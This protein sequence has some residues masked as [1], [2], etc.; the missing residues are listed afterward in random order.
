MENGKGVN[1]VGCLLVACCL[2]LG[3]IIFFVLKNIAK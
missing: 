1:F 2:V 3:A